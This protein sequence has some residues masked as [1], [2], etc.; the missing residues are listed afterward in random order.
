MAYT[1]KDWNHIRTGDPV[2]VFMGAGWQKGTLVLKHGDSVTV[3]LPT[4]T[5]RVFD[6]RN[7]R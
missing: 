6:P 3:R 5:I 2:R 7:I 1:L 4:R